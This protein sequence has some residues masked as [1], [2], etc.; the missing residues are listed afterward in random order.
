EGHHRRGR[1]CRRSGRGP[2]DDHC[3]DGLADRSNPGGRELEVRPRDERWPPHRRSR[4]DP[5]EF[6]PERPESEWIARMPSWI[7][8]RTRRRKIVFVHCATFR[9]EVVLTAW[10]WIGMCTAGT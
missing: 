7:P 6:F 9:I 2:S 8:L 4:G 3:R 10:G 1:A 5:G